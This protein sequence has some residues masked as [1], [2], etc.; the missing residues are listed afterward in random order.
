MEGIW[1]IVNTSMI[2][3]EIFEGN[4]YDFDNSKYPDYGGEVG[5]HD[6]WSYR[7]AAVG[8]KYNHEID[9]FE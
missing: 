4:L 9:K 2:C 8:K 5:V 3:L 6:Q 7:D 1:A